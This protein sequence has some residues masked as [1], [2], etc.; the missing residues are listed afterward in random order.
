QLTRATFHTKA[1]ID[2]ICRM[3][4]EA[5]SNRAKKIR[6]LSETSDHNFCE[7]NEYFSDELFRLHTPAS[8]LKDTYQPFIPVLWN[9]MKSSV[10][11]AEPQ[12]N[13]PSMNLET[14][15]MELSEASTASMNE[16][17][18]KIYQLLRLRI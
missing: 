4:C 10:D 18:S 1:F 5:N 3:I 12:L 17:Q 6:V 15:P 8:P 7:F 13:S 11:P 9:T 2:E 14:I 16:I